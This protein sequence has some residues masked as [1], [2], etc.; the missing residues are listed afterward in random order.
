[1]GCHTVGRSEATA[2]PD[3]LESANTD[4]S[5]NLR[6]SFYGFA[7]APRSTSSCGKSTLVRSIAETEHPATA[8]SLD[9]T[10]V[11]AGAERDP[12]GIREQRSHQQAD[13]TDDQPTVSHFRDRD[14]SEIDLILETRAGTVAAIE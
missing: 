2:G 3:P 12:R 9:D 5:T 8:L 7:G 13:F 14:G 6:S 4:R 11:R 10:N 1:M